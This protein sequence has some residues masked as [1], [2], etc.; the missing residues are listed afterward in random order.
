M[1]EISVAT[2]K[3]KPHL[4]KIKIEIADISFFIGKCF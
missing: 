3:V 4:F 2:S 1:N